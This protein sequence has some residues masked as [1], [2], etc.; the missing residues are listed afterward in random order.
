[1]SVTAHFPRETAAGQRRRI[2]LPSS[3]VC[4]CLLLAEHLGPEHIRSRTGHVYAAANLPS[5]CRLCL[6]L[7][8]MNTRRPAHPLG[9]V[10]VYRPMCFLRT[11]NP[12]TS[13]S[14]SSPDTRQPHPH[15]PLCPLS[16]RTFV[17]TQHLPPPSVPQTPNFRP[18]SLSATLAVET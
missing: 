11:S 12:D 8:Q 10:L 9:F 7:H 4:H 1:M 14:Q 5:Y 2:C 18:S 16:I 6:T 13:P 3:A 15:Y 17:F